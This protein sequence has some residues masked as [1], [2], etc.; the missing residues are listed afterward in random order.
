MAPRKTKAGRRHNA[1][2][3]RRNRK[4]N[5]RTNVA[6]HA[7][8]S[9]KTSLVPTPGPDYGCNTMYTLRGAIKLSNFNRASTVAQA[10]QFYRIKSVKLTV[11]MPFDTFAYDATNNI[12]RPNLYYMVDKAEAIPALAS[13]ETLKQM[14]ARPRQCD[15]KPTTITFTPS[16]LSSTETLAGDAPS[17]FNISPWLS[18][19]HPDIQHNGLFWYAEQFF[20]SAISYKVEMEIQFEFKKP[21]WQQASASTEAIRSV[22]ATLDNSSNGIVDSVA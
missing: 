9:V 16:V 6:D 3:A 18:T 13:L 4:N 14:G 10:Y 19:A 15:E 7:S 8:C 12:S 5:K 2:R 1:A 20:G 11:R 21:V 17:L 22:P